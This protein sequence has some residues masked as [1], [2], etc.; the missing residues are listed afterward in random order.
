[1]NLKF[2]FF[3]YDKIIIFLDINLT[4]D[5]DRGIT[6]SPYRKPTANNTI[7]EASSC[8]LKHVITNIPVGELIRTKRNCTDD[9][10]Y[11]QQKEQVCNRLQSRGYPTW[12]LHRIEQKVVNIPRNDLLYNKK[13]Q[14]T[15]SNKNKK[16]V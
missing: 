5:L 11:E 10:T 7:L 13:K 1:M 14:T 6:I 16:T 15:V 2:T 4:G 8:H 3:F 12:S 9:N